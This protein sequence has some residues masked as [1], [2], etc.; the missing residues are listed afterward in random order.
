M[1]V[2]RRGVLDER[3][4]CHVTSLAYDFLGHSGQL[5]LLDGDCCDMRGCVALF[6]EIDPKVT[7]IS[8][9]AGDKTDT[10]YRKEGKKWHALTPDGA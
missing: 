10:L 2:S 1:S 9:Y 4:M 6:E 5:Y 8:T 3:L 7:S